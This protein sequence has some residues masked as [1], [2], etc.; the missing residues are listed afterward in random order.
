[1]TSF[2]LIV[3]CFGVGF[4]CEDRLRLRF[5]GHFA[6]VLAFKRLMLEGQLLLRDGWSSPRDSS[7][8]VI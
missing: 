7:V 2:A 8:H 4:F 6:S 3:N 1:M 5:R